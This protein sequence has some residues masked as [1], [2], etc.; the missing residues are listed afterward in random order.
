MS[1]QS[2][3][4]DIQVIILHLEAF[5]HVLATF[6]L[7][8][9]IASSTELLVSKFERFMDPK[10]GW[11]I[12][13]TTN[14][15]FC[16]SQWALWRINWYQLYTDLYTSADYFILLHMI[17]KEIL[18]CLPL[19]KDTVITILKLNMGLQLRINDV[20]KNWDWCF[21]IIFGVRWIVKS[22]PSCLLLFFLD[23]HDIRKRI[24]SHIQ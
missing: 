20:W 6:T 18:L 5:I 3:F 16:K 1:I 10:H 24:T 8:F 23:T 17:Y 15:K 11:N 13:R 9:Q 22:G 4:Q 12:R 19:G 21:K 2:C 14:Q 7:K